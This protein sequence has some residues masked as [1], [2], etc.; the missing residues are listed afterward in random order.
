MRSH[1]YVWTSEYAQLNVCS[2]IAYTIFPQPW[3]RESLWVHKFRDRAYFTFLCCITVL[4]FKR[5]VIFLL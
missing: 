4:S 2:G 3:S 5:F 1:Y